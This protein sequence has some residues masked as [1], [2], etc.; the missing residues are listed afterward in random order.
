MVH[1][2]GGGDSDGA[3]AG[4]LLSPVTG[5]GE[6]RTTPDTRGLKTVGMTRGLIGE[7]LGAATTA[8]E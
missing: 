7:G 1:T 8:L 2:R 5:I 6:G 4:D 3:T